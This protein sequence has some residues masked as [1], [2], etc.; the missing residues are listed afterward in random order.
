MNLA[1]IL[2][3]L[4][5]AIGSIVLSS[6][7]CALYWEGLSLMFVR[8]QPPDGCSRC[9]RGIIER[10]TASSAGD[11]FYRCTCCEARYRRPSRGGLYQDASAPEFDRAFL[12]RTREGDWQKPLPPAE[13]ETYWTRT[14]DTLVWCKR[15]RCPSE[16]KKQPSEEWRGLEHVLPLWDRE[17][18]P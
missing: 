1:P 18:D 15:S 6:L 2:M 13:G 11:R 14:I 5:C 3:V 10:V 7:F 12:R 8:P 9:Q 4:G 17:I 16:A